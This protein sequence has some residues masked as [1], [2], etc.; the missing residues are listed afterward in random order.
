MANVRVSIRKRLSRKWLDVPLLVTL[1]DS[2]C[3]SELLKL[4]FLKQ[5]YSIVQGLLTPLWGQCITLNCYTCL[6]GKEKETNA[7]CTWY[8]VAMMILISKGW[9]QYWCG[10]KKNQNTLSVFCVRGKNAMGAVGLQ[11]EWRLQCLSAALLGQGSHGL[12]GGS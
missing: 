6:K 2:L 3:L 9:L 11:V 1:L 8:F 12:I 5:I 7:V 4:V 10:Q